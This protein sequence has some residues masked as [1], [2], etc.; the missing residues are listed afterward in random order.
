MKAK[1][2]LMMLAVSLAAL[3]AEK[4]F[5]AK[6]FK[7]STVP[8]VKMETVDGKPFLI[9]DIPKGEVSKKQNCA[10]AK[11]RFETAWYII[12]PM[13][14]QPNTTSTIIAPDGS[15]PSCMHSEVE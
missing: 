1:H 4:V 14:F 3:A 7:W 13:P 12:W 2:I 5:T 9:V 11:S 15:E 8:G 10:V 6:D